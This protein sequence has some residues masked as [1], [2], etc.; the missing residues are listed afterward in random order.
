MYT[1]LL[2]STVLKDLFQ[3]WNFILRINQ[4][5]ETRF[6]ENGVSAPL[7]LRGFTLTCQVNGRTCKFIYFKFSTLPAELFFPGNGIS[8][9]A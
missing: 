9:T 1:I 6:L 5:T 7:L 2:F 4:K 3:F 8:Q